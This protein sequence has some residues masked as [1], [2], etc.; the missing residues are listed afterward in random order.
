MA[1]AIGRMLAEFLSTVIGFTG[2]WVLLG[3]IALV[4]TI[5][6]GRGSVCAAMQASAGSYKKQQQLVRCFKDKACGEA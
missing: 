1:G 6:M 3:V 2:A 4:L 5:Y